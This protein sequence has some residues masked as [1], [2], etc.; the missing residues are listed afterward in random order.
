MPVTP[1]P[2]SADPL[3]VAVGEDGSAVAA[4][5]ALRARLAD[6]LAARPARLVVDLGGCS[7]LDAPG[8]RVLLDAGQQAREQGT[9]LEL[10]HCPPDVLRL[11]DASG[12]ADVLQPA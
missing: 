5:F 10:R 8:L 1:V 12:Q 3:V 7:W 9:A 11:L 2:P 6:A 4:E